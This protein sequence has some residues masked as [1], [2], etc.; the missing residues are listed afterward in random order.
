MGIPGILGVRGDWGWNFGD[1][2][3]ELWGFGVKLWQLKG[4][5]VGIF[6]TG[7]DWR[8]N[9]LGFGE[10]WM[11]YVGI[12]GNLGWNFVDLGGNFWDFG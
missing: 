6:G 8:G 3:R 12:K 7:E 4:A 1:L 9:F 11:E 10:I 5:G 2:G